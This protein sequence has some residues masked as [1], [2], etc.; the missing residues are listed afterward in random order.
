MMIILNKI[1]KHGLRR[2][3]KIAGGLLSEEFAKWRTRKAPAFKNPTDSELD[4]IELALLDLGVKIENYK[5]DPKEFYAF[6]TAG[7]FSD[8]YHGGISGPVWNEKVLEHY[9]AAERLG[10]YSYKREDV[11]VD[12]AAAGSPWAKSLRDKLGISAFA[13]DVSLADSEYKDLPFY[14]VENAT[15]MEFENESVKGASLQCA[16]EMFMGDDDTNVLNEFSRILRP[17]G[18]ILILPLYLHTHYC[19]YSSP[20]YYGKGH[21]DPLSKEYIYREWKGIPSAR[22]YDA[23][24]LKRRVL[25]PIEALGMKYQMFTLKNKKDLGSN[26]YC[27]FILE[28]TK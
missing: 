8:D 18:K 16:Y 23:V 17:G 1:K 3:V 5:V 4:D 25:D 22:F 13:I 10:L 2:S 19:A 15:A 26:I 11:Y 27:H 20:K 12:V 21:S 14:R 24:S 7:Y 9:L 28:I 6:K